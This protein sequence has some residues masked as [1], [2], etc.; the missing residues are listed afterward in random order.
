MKTNIFSVAVLVMV[1]LMTACDNEDNWSNRRSAKVSDAKTV[2]VY[3]AGRNDL[4]TAVEPDLEEIK[5]G[6]RQLG[7]NDNLLVFVRHRLQR[8]GEED[9]LRI[10]VRSAIPCQAQLCTIQRGYQAV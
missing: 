7:P 3:M 1:V 6:S 8:H 4:S 2:L 5:A 10:D 9:A